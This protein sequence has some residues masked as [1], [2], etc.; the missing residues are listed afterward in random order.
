MNQEFDF[1]S[2]ENNT[3]KSFKRVKSYESVSTVGEIEKVSRSRNIPAHI[4]SEFIEL[5]TTKNHSMKE[6]AKKMKMSYS[7]AKKIYS[8]FRRTNLEKNFTFCEEV[9]TVAG[10][11]DI[12]EGTQAKISI[13]CMIAGALETE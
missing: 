2:V 8:R 10:Y 6:A 3:G 12:E 13:I 4:K 9:E 11:K 1:V 7:T 5:I